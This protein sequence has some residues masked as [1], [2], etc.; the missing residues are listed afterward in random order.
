[1]S[2]GGVCH[3]K[4]R[5]GT[6]LP[7][8]GLLEITTPPRWAVLTPGHSEPQRAGS[9]CP[10]HPLTGKRGCPSPVPEGVRGAAA[11]SRAFT[12]ASLASMRIWISARAASSAAPDSSAC[13]FSKF[14]L[15]ACSGEGLGEGQ[16]ASATWYVPLHPQSHKLL[17]PA[18]AWCLGF[19][20][21]THPQVQ[22]VQGHSLFGQ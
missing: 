21:D 14:A 1:M 10:E 8:A 13:A 15:A 5:G 4:S 17:D 7:P 11:Y 16:V 3:P 22:H 18:A 19:P 9:P 12:S 2:P 20:S 6:T